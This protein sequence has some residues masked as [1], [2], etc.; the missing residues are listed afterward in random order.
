MDKDQNNSILDKVTESVKRIVL[1]RVNIGSKGIH[2]PQKTHS[3]KNEYLDR[4]RF[5]VPAD[6]LSPILFISR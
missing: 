2:L 5:S 1:S 3:P 6:V 4:T